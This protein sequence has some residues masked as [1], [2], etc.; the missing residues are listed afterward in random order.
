[1]GYPPPQMSTGVEY[2]LFI[3][4]AICERYFLIVHCV[5]QDRIFLHFHGL[6]LFLILHLDL[7]WLR[8]YLEIYAN[9]LCNVVCNY[10]YFSC[11]C[12]GGSYVNMM[13]AREGLLFRFNEKLLFIIAIIP[14]YITSCLCQIW[15]LSFF[16]FPQCLEVLYSIPHLWKPHK[17][18]LNIWDDE[19]RMGKTTKF[20]R[21]FELAK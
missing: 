6:V 10:L 15:N 11:F 12:D 20:E 8:W 19:T 5:I 2:N 4:C 9:S 7:P 21:T 14:S 3:S 18:S 16:H 13:A 17:K 1:M